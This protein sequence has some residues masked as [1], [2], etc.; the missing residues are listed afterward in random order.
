M[1]VFPLLRTVKGA[2]NKMSMTIEKNVRVT[3]E[4]LKNEKLLIKDLRW[5]LYKQRTYCIYV[6]HFY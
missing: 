4:M 5:K 2:D 3:D 1:I 6:I